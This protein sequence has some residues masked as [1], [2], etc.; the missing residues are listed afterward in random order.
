MWLTAATVYS[1][2]YLN[3]IQDQPQLPFSI[4]LKTFEDKRRLP[5]F[6]SQNDSDDILLLDVQED[7]DARYQEVC[8]EW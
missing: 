6:L 5:W 4:V 2:R 1:L 8:G 7:R 3:E